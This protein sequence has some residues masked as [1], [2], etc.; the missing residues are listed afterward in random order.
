MAGM[1][2]AVWALLKAGH[3][4]A[5]KVAWLAVSSAVSMAVLMAAYWESMMAASL[6]V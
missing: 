4:A 1:M 5:W 3:S 2:V 6:A